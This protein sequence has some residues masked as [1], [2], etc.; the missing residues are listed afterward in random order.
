[1]LPPF[2]RN[3]LGQYVYTQNTIRYRVEWR[4]MREALATIGSVKHLFDGGAGSGEFARKELEGGWCQQV[5][6]L[7]YEP[8]NFEIL[9]A[10]LG[11]RPNV[12]L[13]AGSLLEIPFEDAGFDLVQCTQVLEH[14]EDHERAASEL[15]RVLKPGGH[16]LITVPHPPE[17]FPNEGHVREGYTEADLEGLFA[18]LGCRRLRTDFFIT[19]PTLDRMLGA[20]KLPVK[21]VYV[22][23]QWIDQEGRTTLEERRAQ[24][25]FGILML[26]QKQG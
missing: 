18:P 21:G 25:P 16:A 10:K 24:R 7:E 2:L 5:T 12:T 1:M 13:R 4:R 17:P 23:V 14:I 19:R 9:K 6:A 11:G 20:E 22:P 3:L 26:F 8:A 15:I